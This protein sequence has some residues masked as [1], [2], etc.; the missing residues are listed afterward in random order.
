MTAVYGDTPSEPQG[1]WVLPGEYTVKLTVDGQSQEQP[2]LVKMDPRVK[3]PVKGLELQFAI[4]LQSWEGIGT[5]QA[6]LKQV[7]TLRT[8]LKDLREPAA[9]DGPLAD[10]LAALDKKAAALEGASAQG[11][12][13]GP[14]R[15]AASGRED[16]LTRLSFE[17][18][19]LLARVE[20]ADATP[21]TPVVEASEQLQKTLATVLGRWDALKARDLQALNE[22][23][24]KAKL[25]VVDFGS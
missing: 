21:T 6:T 18:N 13:G 17:L 11:R 22:L 25:Q 19:S 4:A 16:S 7:R 12:R 23:L 10:A 15:F 1:P 8:R 14:G 2:L 9:K 20:Q 24:R 3:T 5:V